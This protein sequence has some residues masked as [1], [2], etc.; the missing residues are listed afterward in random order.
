MVVAI[1]QR[2]GNDATVLV[3]L[4]ADSTVDE[5]LIYKTRRVPYTPYYQTF[6]S[7]KKYSEDNNCEGGKFTQ[8]RQHTY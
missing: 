5:K 2:S 3:G 8:W 4:T 6:H 1:R 7:Y